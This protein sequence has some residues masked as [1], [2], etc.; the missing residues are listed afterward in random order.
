MI[1]NKSM[2]KSA[3]ATGIVIFL[4]CT[5]VVQC[6]EENPKEFVN[7]I[8]ELP[9][10]IKPA[11]RVVN[12]N[13]TLWIEANIA[14][15]IMEYYSQTKYRIEDFDFNLSIGLR[16]LTG[17][18]KDLSDQ[19]GVTSL[20]QIYAQTGSVP[21][22]GET[23]SPIKYLYDGNSYKC[24]IAIIPKQSG[25]YCVNFLSPMDLNLRKAIT[26]EPTNDGRQ[27]VPVYEDL[28]IVLNNG[29]TNFDLFQ[30]Y[31]KANS[32]E[33][34]FIRNIYYEQKGTYTFEVRQ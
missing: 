26:L 8:L 11:A 27:K 4:I 19:P 7:F 33:H 12:I 34:P 22:L 20:F 28:F 10:L 3:L 15:S 29:E 23:F 32:I 21:T 25:I 16:R 5:T 14:D 13:D 24:R 18:Q 6:K 30:Q 1:I 31:C 9:M 2:P 17:N